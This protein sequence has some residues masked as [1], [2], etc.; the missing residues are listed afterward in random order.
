M[1][2]IVTA[3]IKCGWKLATNQPTVIVCG[4]CKTPQKIGDVETK[5]NF[6]ECGYQATSTVTTEITCPLCSRTFEVVSK[7]DLGRRAWAALHAMENPTPEEYQAWLAMVPSYGC[8]CRAHWDELTA[9]HP[10]DFENFPQWA[11]DR[12]NDVNIRLGKPIWSRPTD[13]P[14]T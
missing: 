1:A 3:C 12:H 8:L 14:S 6:C 13:A 4:Q 7:D 5:T 2:A 10:P 9:K 11:I